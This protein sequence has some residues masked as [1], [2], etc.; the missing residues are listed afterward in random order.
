[1]NRRN[2]CSIASAGALGLGL[3]EWGRARTALTESSSTHVNSEASTERG[4]WFIEGRYGLMISFSVYALLGRGSWAIHLDQIPV[5][6]YKQLMLRFDPAG[7]SAKEWVQLAIDAGQRYL[8]FIAKHRDGFC[9][10]DTRLSEFSI[11]RSPFGRDICAELAEECRRRSIVFNIYYQLRDWTY[12][13][14]RQSFKPGS[15][16]S[17]EYADYVHGQVRELCSNYGKLGA[18]WFDGGVD[19][20]PEQWRAAEL[21]TMIRNLQPDALIDDRTGLLGDFS[22]P[23]EDF[24]GAVGGLAHAESE[25]VF[26]PPAANRLWERCMTVND[27]WGYDSS[28]GRYKSPDKI[29]QLL[30]QTVAAGGNL[31]LDVAPDS[32]GVI[33]R[34][35]AAHLRKAGEWLEKN[36]DSIYGAQFSR[37]IYYNGVYATQKGSNVYLHIFDWEPGALCDLP[38][39]GIGNAD[40]V[41]FLASGEELHLASSPAGLRLIARNPGREQSADTVVVFENAKPARPDDGSVPL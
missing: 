31:V 13:A 5:H 9:L 27:H 12:P 11:M 26:H 40:R 21:L 36:G 25:M 19:H 33:D 41:Y 38:L 18:I 4:K 37:H 16:V 7:F 15:S 1:M 22:T 20:T 35:S 23:E 32:S 10:F 28:G 3:H 2:F 8:T 24:A 14:Y 30:V 29:I 39:L 17:Q 34:V 6:E